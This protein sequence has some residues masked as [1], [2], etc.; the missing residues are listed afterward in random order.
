MRDRLV[1]LLETA[2]TLL[3]SAEPTLIRDAETGPNEVSLFYKALLRDK[4]TEWLDP[5]RDD[6]KGGLDRA[7]EAASGTPEPPA[8]CPR[9]DWKGD[10]QC[11][12][13]EGHEGPDLF[14]EHLCSGRVIVTP[15]P[16]TPGLDVERLAR[17]MAEVWP[18]SFRGEFASDN[19]SRRLLTGY[20]ERIARE[21]A[22]L[23]E[24]PGGEK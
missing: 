3:I 23:A 7:L 24:T 2:Y 5:F 9:V 6:F 14:A 21:Y 8:P 12:L 19:P 18:V 11:G 1:A 15:P 17:A 20:A 16:A 4:V 13:H 10:Q 22:A